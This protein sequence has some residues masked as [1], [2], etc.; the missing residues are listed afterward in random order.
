MIGSYIILA[1]WSFIVLF[2]I[3]WL[4]VT[5]VKLPISV[6]DGPRFLPYVDFT[7]D[8]HAWRYLLTE[9][10]GHIVERPYI[11]TFVVGTSS[12]VLALFIGAL[13]SY[14]LVRFTYRLKLSLVLSFIFSIVLGIVLYNV[15]AAWPLAAAVGLVIFLLA[16]QTIGKRFTKSLENDDVAFWLISQRMLPPVA[17]VIPIYILFQQVGLLNTR[18]ALIITYTAV[19]LPLA[20]WFLRDYFQTI[21]IELEESAFIDGA[22][23]FQVLS[24]IVLPLSVPGLVATFL[25]VLVFAWNEY[26]LGLFLSGADTQTMPVLVVAQN[27]TRG[28]QWWNISALVLMMIVPVIVL[29]IILERYIS[30]GILVGAVKG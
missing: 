10:S 23:R 5:S 24:K 15:G 28:P 16:V 8:L 27:A 13:A 29:A 17:V 1:I 2:P 4:I 22:S 6:S 21:P 25:I 7:P 26:L 12:A 14:A 18:A 20:V 9:E 11:N 30:R 19:N 3:F